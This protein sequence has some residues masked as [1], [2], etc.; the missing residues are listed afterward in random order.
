M[1]GFASIEEVDT[2]DEGIVNK[3]IP[4][5][6]TPSRSTSRAM[7]QS[8]IT[9]KSVM[10]AKSDSNARSMIASKTDTTTPSKVHYYMINHIDCMAYHSFILNI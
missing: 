10:T 8:C 2:D 1:Q 4:Q 5:P 6:T 3:Y 9:A 7:A